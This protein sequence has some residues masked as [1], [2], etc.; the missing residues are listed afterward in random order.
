MVLGLGRL[1]AAGRADSV[2]HCISCKFSISTEV[3]QT[4]KFRTPRIGKGLNWELGLEVNPLCS[5]WQSLCPYTPNS[6]FSG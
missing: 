2:L 1:I 3:L 5:V 6:R 4:A